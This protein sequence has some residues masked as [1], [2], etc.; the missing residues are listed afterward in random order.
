MREER[1]G[2]SIPIKRLLFEYTATYTLDKT[3]F[4]DEEHDLLKY[5][6]WIHWI[7]G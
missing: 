2:I 5:F 6:T 7:T 1:R 4:N 3:Y